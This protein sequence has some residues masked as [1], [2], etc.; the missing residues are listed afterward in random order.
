[1]EPQT[2]RMKRKYRRFAR[3][4]DFMEVA[5]RVP[6]AI[7]PRRALTDKIP[8][9]SSLGI[10]DLCCGT[11]NGVLALGNSCHQIVAV[12]VSAHMLA[13]AARKLRQNGI[14]NVAPAQMDAARLAFADERFDV[15]T[16][17]FAMH[18]FEHD[19]MCAVLAE[20]CRVLRPGGRLYIAD[21]AAQTDPVRRAAF[22]VYLRAVYPPHVRNFLAYDWAEILGRVGFELDS[23]DR[24]SFSALITATRA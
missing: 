7:D 5:F 8:D 12:D 21:Y 3:V 2:E 23:I 13:V 20:A 10:L 4:Y 6:G 15:V 19:E 22:A 24:C 18:E 14:D 11:G 9:A 17:S 16:T 1:M